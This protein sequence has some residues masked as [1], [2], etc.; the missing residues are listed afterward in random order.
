[1]P[2]RSVEVLVL[3]DVHLGTY[4]SRAK[5]LYVYLRSISPKKVILNGDII[6]VWLFSNTYWPSSHTLVLKQILSW[7][8]EGVEVIYVTGNHDEMFRRFSGFELGGL[9]VVNKY[10]FEVNGKK[11]LVFHGDVFDVTMK[12]SKWIAK[13]GAIGYDFLVLLNLYINKLMHLMGKERVSLSKKIKNSVKGAVKFIDDFEETITSIAVEKGF[14]MVF[15]GHIHQPV[16]KSYK[17]FGKE[18]LYLNSGDWIENLTALEFND[19]QWS[20]YNYSHE[21]LTEDKVDQALPRHQTLQEIFAQMLV[22]FE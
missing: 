2:K 10:A 8:S 17:K 11:A 9:Q 16:I 7:L 22:E 12:H 1:M 21:E 3:S 19:N 4:G 18:V 6:D 20:L 15:C 13:L 5:E 14:D